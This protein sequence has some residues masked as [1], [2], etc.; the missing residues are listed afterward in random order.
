MRRLGAPVAAPTHRP[1]R[2]LPPRLVEM[3]PAQRRVA[4]HSQ[5]VLLGSW[6]EAGRSRR[7]DDQLRNCSVPYNRASDLERLLLR[8]SGESGRREASRT[9]PRWLHGIV[10]SR[11]IERKPR[12]VAPATALGLRQVGRATVKPRFSAAFS[13]RSSYVTI[14]ARS[15]PRCCAVAR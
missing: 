4:I 11:I 2:L 13:M 15:A 8:A 1:I 14:R 12:R 10:L 3:T 6:L 7:E 9:A 5:A